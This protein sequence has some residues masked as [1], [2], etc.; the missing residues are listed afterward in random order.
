MLDNMKAMTVKEAVSEASEYLEKMAYEKN[1]G[2]ICVTL[3][4]Y[5]GKPV[6]LNTA[7]CEHL[8]KRKK[9]ILVVKR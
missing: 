2:D 5:K 7:F 6:K 3:T 1:G 9:T 4:M 8:I